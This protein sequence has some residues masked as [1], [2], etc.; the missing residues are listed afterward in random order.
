MALTEAQQFV[1]GKVRSRIRYSVG[2]KTDIPKILLIKLGA[3]GE[4][5]MASPFFDQL[6]KHFPHSEIILVVGRSSFAVV[7]H[8]PNID[9]FVLANDLAFYHGSVLARIFE[10]FRLIFKLRKEDFNLSFVLQNAWPFHL[11]SGLAGVPL[12]V[13]LGYRRKD[14]FLT[15][16]VVADH[17]QNETES[18]L[19]LLR[20]MNFPAVSKK[21]SYY[22]SGEEKDFLDL[23]LE[24]Y[25][26]DSGEEVIAIAPGG[27]ESVKR[28]MLTKRWPV[29]CY[30]ELVQRLQYGRS[31]RIVLVGGFGDR[32][33]TNSII[34]SCPNCLDATDLS[35]GEMASIFRRCDLF[36]G[37]DSAPYHIASSMGTPCIGIFGPTDP[38]Q[39]ASLNT[40]TS[41]IVK[42]V[43]CHPCFKRGTFPKCS[44]I[45]CLTSITVDDVWQKLEPSVFSVTQKLT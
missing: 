31:C 9:R 8:N 34:Q 36:I 24:R 32:K 7:E 33:V 6:R 1:F 37:N 30:I 42:P 2:N 35:F 20:K 10:F 17:I 40:N 18:Y 38:R 29:Q 11:L 21:T 39:W 12:R 14:F 13:G 44:H 4:L 43:E 19:D 16:S 41:V 23:F 25:S 28:T 27:G 3:I 5:V 45:R 26:I 22:L 15:H